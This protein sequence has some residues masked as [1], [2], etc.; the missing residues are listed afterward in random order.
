MQKVTGS[1]PVTS[2]SPDN[3]Q[4][5]KKVA[6]FSFFSGT[7]IRSHYQRNGYINFFG[8]SFLFVKKEFF[9]KVE[10]ISFNAIIGVSRKPK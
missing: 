6:L 2:T 4:F 10:L 7:L 9:S 1:T 5:I 3:F 8:S